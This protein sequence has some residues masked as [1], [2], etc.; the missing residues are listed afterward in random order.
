CDQVDADRVELARQRRDLQLGADAVGAG[1]QDRL[2]VSAG[3]EPAVDVQGEEAGEPTEAVENPGAVRFLGQSAD[4]ADRVLVDVQVQ[5]GRFVV[6]LF[7]H[8]AWSSGW[9]CPWSF[10]WPG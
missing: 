3:E 7:G 10:G 2:L 6:E 8:G 1:D 5:A 9:K 4:P